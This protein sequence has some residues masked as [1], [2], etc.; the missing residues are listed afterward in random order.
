MPQ[1]FADLESACAWLE[2]R[3]DAL[4]RTAVL[5]EHQVELDKL[6]WDLMRAVGQG[7]TPLASA[8]AVLEHREE[9]AV[10]LDVTVSR[11]IRLTPIAEA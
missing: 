8:L 2:R 10:L 6:I 1:V 11:A 3:E 4:V 7:V 9:L 5:C